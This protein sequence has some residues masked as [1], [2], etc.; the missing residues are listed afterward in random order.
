MVVDFAF[1][2]APAYRVA[3]IGWKGPWDDKRIR[4]EFARLAKWAKEHGYRPGRWFFRE[5]G[6]R[7][8]EVGIEVHGAK[9]HAHPPVR[10]RTLPAA[11][12]ASVVF[13]PEAVSPR[14]VYHG[15]VDWLRWR[16]KE[17]KIRSVGTTREVYSGN[18]YTDP[19]AWAKTEVQFLVRP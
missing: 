18:P 8:W 3:C 13:D 19:K 17:G 1:K 9:I 6:T 11:R 2:R 16:R 15:L 12:V 10:L 14:V 5:P 4:A 7:R